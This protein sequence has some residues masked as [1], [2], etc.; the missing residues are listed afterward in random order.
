MLVTDEMMDKL[1]HS[2]LT[3]VSE[4]KKPIFRPRLK[5]HKLMGEKRVLSMNV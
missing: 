3:R 5:I 4:N 1:L 2:R